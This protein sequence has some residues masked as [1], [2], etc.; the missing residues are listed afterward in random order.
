MNGPVPRAGDMDLHPAVSPGLGTWVCTLQCCEGWGHGSAPSSVPRAGDTGLSSGLGTQ[1]C[2]Q[3][4]GHRSALCPVLRVGDMGLCPAVSPGLGTTVCVLEAGD[5]GLHP[6]VS[7]GWGH[8]SVL[9][10]P[11]ISRADDGAITPAKTR[12]TV[13]KASANTFP[14][15]DVAATSELPLCSRFASPSNL[16]SPRSPAPTF[17]TARVCFSHRQPHSLLTPAFIGFLPPLS[18]FPSFSRR[19]QTPRVLAWVL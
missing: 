12:P 9:A 4:W 3:G 16:P 14:R 13:T 7:P 1:V 19:R 17:V 5:S 18:P 8:R 6:A 15:R 2:S 10:T 11:E